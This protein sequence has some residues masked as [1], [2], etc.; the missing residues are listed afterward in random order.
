MV[1]TVASL[2]VP[3]AVAFEVFIGTSKIVGGISQD[4]MVGFHAVMVA[5][6]IIL[7]IAGILSWTRGKE[8]RGG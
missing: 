1:I 5:S 8:N 2:A 4:F 3:R 6:I 7:A